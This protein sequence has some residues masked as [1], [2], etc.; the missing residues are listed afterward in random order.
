MSR[1]KEPELIASQALEQLSALRERFGEKK[2]QEIKELVAKEDGAAAVRILLTDY[3]D[4]LYGK[5]IRNCD[6]FEL[7]VSGTDAR[8]AARVILEK[9]ASHETMSP[10]L[11]DKP[12]TAM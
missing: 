8:E 9:F 10:E 4:P 7:S 1:A 3:Y 5:Q 11:H 12:K 6:W 2:L